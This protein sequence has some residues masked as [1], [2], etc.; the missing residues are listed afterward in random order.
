MDESDRDGYVVL[1]GAAPQEAIDA[2][3]RERVELR[4]G[5]L[6]REP[7]ADHVSLA[8]QSSP[9]AAAVDP[10]ALSVGARALLLSEPLTTLLHERFGEAPLLFDATESGDAAPQDPYRD[11][12][13]VALATEPET[14]TTAA[15]ALGDDVTITVFPGS[16]AIATTPFSGRY[17]HHN[18]ERD[19]D[20][21]L[22]RHHDEL[23]SALGEPD[24]ITLQR[25]DV[26]VWSA[27]LVHGPVAGP[28]LV[29]HLSPARV[30]PGWFAY[31]PERARYADHHG[32]A[33]IATQHYDLLDAVT[34]VEDEQAPPEE[35]AFERIEDALREHDDDQATEQ[36]PP[37]AGTPRRAGGL[38]DSVRG[39]LGRRGR[40]R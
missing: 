8:T 11:A 6:V 5:L 27:D 30:A 34:R 29:A 33:Q 2:Y 20:G 9:D 21:A 3:A 35:S 18:A 25:G 36:T 19:G 39:M 23:R 7:G 10:Y 32:R 15:V 13:F 1:R 17:R 24:T 12:T 26:L 14:L 40:G 31:R 22:T 16:Q 28:A 38:V 4:D 37:A